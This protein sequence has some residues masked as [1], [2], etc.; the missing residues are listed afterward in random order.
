VT[1]NATDTGEIF[2]FGGVSCGTITSN[3]Y[4]LNAQDK[5]ISLVQTFGQVPTARLGH[6]VAENDGYLVLWG[7]GATS[8]VEVPPDDGLYLLNISAYYLSSLSVYEDAL[9]LLKAPKN[10]YALASPAAL[11]EGVLGTRWPWQGPKCS[12]SGE[13]QTA[14]I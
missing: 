1:S 2:I 3:L 9:I 12:S 13:G 5:S 11:L 4:V 6:A 8:K 14:N 10:G 7:G